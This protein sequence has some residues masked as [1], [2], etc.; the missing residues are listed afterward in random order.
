MASEAEI[1]ENEA[2]GLDA[3]AASATAPWQ[4]AMVAMAVWVFGFGGRI[5]S[6]RMIVRGG[7]WGKRESSESS[8]WLW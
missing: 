6:E 2:Q 7:R 4:M 1:L 3:A 5:N 8:A